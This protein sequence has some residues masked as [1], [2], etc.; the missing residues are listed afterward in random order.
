MAILKYGTQ[1]TVRVSN[2]AG[3]AHYLFDASAVV[4]DN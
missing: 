1:N 4:L 2:L 3:Y